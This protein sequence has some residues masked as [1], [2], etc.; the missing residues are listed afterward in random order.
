MTV[1]EPRSSVPP[2]EW[3][4]GPVSARAFCLREPNPGPMTLDGTNTWVLSEPGADTVVVVDPGEEDEPHLQRVAEHVHARG[5]RVALTLLTHGHHDHAGGA[6]RFAEITGAPTR[7]M[8]R[9][10]DLGDGEQLVVGGLALRVLAAPGHTLDSL[11]LVVPAD[12]ALLTGDTVLGRGT[13]VVAHPDG[14]LAAYLVTLDRL[15][16]V[17]GEGPLTRILPGHG[18]VVE[19]PSAMVAFY[20]A[21]RRDRLEQVRGALADGAR[22]VEEVMQRVYADVPREV[23]PAARQ[24][25]A[26]QLA[27]LEMD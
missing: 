26:A 2:G 8:M 12:A 7:S 20:R 18:P 24:S 14:D 15:A 17:L 4:G 27:Y 19:D 10:G 23:W 11:C 25:V 1:A 21:H 6:R 5:A 13:T 3:D 22:G 9:G 16:K